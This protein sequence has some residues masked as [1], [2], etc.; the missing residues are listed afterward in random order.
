MIQ[1]EPEDFSAC[2]SGCA[3]NAYFRQKYQS[4]KIENDSEAG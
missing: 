4:K 1:Q 3:D 2:V